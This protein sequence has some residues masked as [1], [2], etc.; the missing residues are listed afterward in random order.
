M[1]SLE[2]VRELKSSSGNTNS[3]IA[4]QEKLIIQGILQDEHKFDNNPEVQSVLSDFDNLDFSNGPFN[5]PLY[6]MNYNE[7]KE[8]NP[9]DKIAKYYGRNKNVFLFIAMLRDKWQSE[10]IIDIVSKKCDV[11]A[12]EKFIERMNIYL[13]RVNKGELDAKEFLNSDLAA[14]F[15]GYHTACQGHNCNI[16]KNLNIN[17]TEPEQTLE[18]SHLFTKKTKK[19]ERSKSELK[20]VKIYSNGKRIVTIKKNEKQQRNYF[21]AELAICDIEISWGTEDKSGKDLNCVAVLN[22]NSGQINI[23]KLTIDG[24]NVEL[25]DILE[26]AKQNEAMLIK[27]K[28]LHEVLRKCLVQQTLYEEKKDTQPHENIVISTPNSTIDKKITVE[29]GIS[30]LQQGTITH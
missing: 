29:K 18:I 27:G 5:Y 8:A 25:K 10:K 1:G 16:Y 6:S 11:Q 9:F 20:R 17:I 21:F 28:A 13:N 2:W 26:L 7:G 24:K 3:N 15:N 23:G 4:S 30:F 14:F 12:Q 19:M 22:I